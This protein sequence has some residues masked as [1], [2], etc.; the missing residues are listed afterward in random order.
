LLSGLSTSVGG[1][2]IF[3][4]RVNKAVNAALLGLAA[5]VMVALSVLDMLLP[6]YETYGPSYVNFSKQHLLGVC[7]A[8]RAL[9]EKRLGWQN[10][11]RNFSL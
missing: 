6:H 11:G 7:G 10:S 8:G 9:I 5:G 2:A 3:C 4:A 1:M